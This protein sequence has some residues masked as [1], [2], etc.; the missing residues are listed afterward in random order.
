MA[1]YSLLRDVIHEFVARPLTREGALLQEFSTVPYLSSAAPAQSVREVI[2]FQGRGFRLPRGIGAGA[3]PGAAHRL[4]DTQMR[5]F[6]TAIDLTVEPREDA[7]GKNWN[8]VRKR[9]ARAID[10]A[11]LA[12]SGL[13][14][15]LHVELDGLW[16]DFV[17]AASRF[18][19]N[20]SSERFAENSNEI[21]LAFASRLDG[22]IA[23]HSV[24]GDAIGNTAADAAD[25]GGPQ[26]DV[27][28]APKKPRRE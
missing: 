28:G 10:I 8:A 19:V 24:L 2:P 14:R 6:A 12:D 1:D 22:L 26:G 20:S 5:R 13:N 27:S 3:F 25:G 9:L 7:E 4:D 18:D 16:L 17:T 21:A 23:G 11:R 15:K